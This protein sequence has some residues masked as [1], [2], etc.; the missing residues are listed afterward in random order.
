MFR[1]PMAEEPSSSPVSVI[2]RRIM[3][4][5]DIRQM[6]MVLEGMWL[7][8]LKTCSEKEMARLERQVI[9]VS[10]EERSQIGRDLHDDLG[11]HLSGVEMLSKVL[12]KKLEAEAPDKAHA[13]GCHQESDPGCH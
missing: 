8:V 5:S 11:S 7:H 1:L 9:A 13:I 2:I 10:Q 4:N 3:I 12:Q 6:R